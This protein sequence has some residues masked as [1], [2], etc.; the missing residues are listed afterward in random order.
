MTSVD[1]EEAMEIEERWAD[2]DVID[3]DVDMTEE[4]QLSLISEIHTT[5]NDLPLAASVDSVTG[6]TAPSLTS[7]VSQ[8]HTNHTNSCM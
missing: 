7:T 3:M 6:Q 2:D 5:R 4:Q 8:W 1:D